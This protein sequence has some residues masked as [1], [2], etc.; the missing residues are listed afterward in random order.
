MAI[1]D[2]RD[3]AMNEQNKRTNLGRGLAA[4]FGEEGEEYAGTDPARAPRTVP[5]EYLHPNRLQPRQTFDSETIEALAESIKTN[6]ILQPILV[7]HHTGQPGEFEIVAGERRWRAAQMAQVDEIPVVIRDVS[8]AQALELALV[9]N[10]QRLD[11][12]PI[13]EAEGFH[14]LIDEFEHTQEELAGIIGKSRSHIAN[15]MR[16]RN[17][18]DDV[19][20][21]V[22]NGSLSAGHGRALLGATDPSAL[23]KKV[24]KRGLNVRQ[25]E[26]LVQ[27]RP[28][29]Q[30][31]P[32][33]TPDTAPEPRA[34]PKDPDTIAL[35]RDLT[36]LLGLIVS[37]DFEAEGGSLTIRYNTLEQL[38]DILR[39]LSQAPDSVPE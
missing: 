11:L 27:G 26:R 32:E 36:A 5:I 13:E 7:R 28:A 21:M 39:R 24:V 3:T 30:P 31:A 33:P 22:G 2:E 8:D 9:E 12:S 37:I 20:E 4:L 19:K 25:T 29:P 15:T 35:E 17:L 34:E 16:L 10:V 23:A 6:G 18:P 14:R 1:S 38:D